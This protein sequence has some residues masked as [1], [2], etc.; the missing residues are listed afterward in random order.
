MFCVLKLKQFLRGDFITP[1]NVRIMPSYACDKVH[2]YMIIYYRSTYCIGISLGTKIA[3]PCQEMN[4]RPLML[5]FG[6]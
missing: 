1:F 2:C 5:Y 4:N 3:L 6:T